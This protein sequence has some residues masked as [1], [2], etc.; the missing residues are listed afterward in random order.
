MK[1]FRANAEA[2][3]KYCRD[4]A[5]TPVMQAVEKLATAQKVQQ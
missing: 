4:N 3:A 5:S 2:V 1:K